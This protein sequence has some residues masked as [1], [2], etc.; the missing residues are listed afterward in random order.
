MV[1]MVDKVG[2]AGTCGHWD[3]AFSESFGFSP[4]VSFSS[5]AALYSHIYNFGDV[6]WARKLPSSHRI[7]TTESICAELK[8]YAELHIVHYEVKLES[9]SN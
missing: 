9:T 3:K 1:F 5:T 8:L 7:T 2:Q 4:S 6:K